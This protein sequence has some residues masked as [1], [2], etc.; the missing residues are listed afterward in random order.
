MIRAKN[1]EN[2]R[3]FVKI[4]YRNLSPFF[5]DTVYVFVLGKG[6]IISGDYF[7]GVL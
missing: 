6:F 7:H 3:K 1:Y 5:L 4:M 2:I